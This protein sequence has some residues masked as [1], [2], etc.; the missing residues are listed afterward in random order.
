[1]GP[2]AASSGT[3]GKIDGCNITV[4]LKIELCGPGANATAVKQDIEKYWNQGSPHAQCDASCPVWSPGCSVKFVADVRV[5]AESDP[6]TPGYDQIKIF[7]PG[8]GTYP[9]S[10]VWVDNM[11]GEWCSVENPK[12]YAHEAGHLMG[13][14]DAYDRD[15]GKDGK[16]NT[17][18]DIC[19]PWSEHE[20]DLMASILKCTEAPTQASIDGIVYTLGIECPCECCPE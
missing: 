5:R 1:M 8:T 20:N 9:F 18:D 10:F 14:I 19:T 7:A 16:L 6:P 12:A 2:L 17:A 11:T 15:P 13:E 4:T 3:S